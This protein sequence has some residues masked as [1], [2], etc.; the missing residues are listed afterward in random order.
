MLQ[1]DSQIGITGSNQ[2]TEKVKTKLGGA[3]D[4]VPI[5][6]HAG[7]AVWGVTVVSTHA[8]WS[9]KWPPERA[10]AEGKGSFAFRRDSNCT[11]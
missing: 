4:P 9:G 5:S 11:V 1:P 7:T 3:G 6:S 8:N 10:H 2:M